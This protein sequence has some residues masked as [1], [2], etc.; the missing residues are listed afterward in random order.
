M[1][2]EDVGQIEDCCEHF[3]GVEAGVDCKAGDLEDSGAGPTVFINVVAIK[4]ID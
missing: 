4:I 3:L 2:G 1:P